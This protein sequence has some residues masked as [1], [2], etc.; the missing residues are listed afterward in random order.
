MPL[1]TEKGLILLGMLIVGFYFIVTF[2]GTREAVKTLNVR[3]GSQLDNSLLSLLIFSILTF[4]I[5]F[6]SCAVLLGAIDVNVNVSGKAWVGYL[7]VMIFFALIMFVVC[8]VGLTSSTLQET[9]TMTVSEVGAVNKI[10]NFLIFGVVASSL[11]LFVSGVDIYANKKLNWVEIL[12][13]E[14]PKRQDGTFSP[15]DSYNFMF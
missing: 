8:L 12:E 10:K 4:G 13:K 15:N 2:A 14:G 3:S 5:L 9:S 7:S 1:S 11:T 6:M